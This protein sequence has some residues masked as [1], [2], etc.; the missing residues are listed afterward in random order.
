MKKTIFMLI[1]MATTLLACHKHAAET[2]AY[3]VAIAIKKPTADGVAVLNQIMPVEVTF[4]RNNGGTIHNVLIQILD[5]K[6]VV[7]KTVADNHA[8]TASPYTYSE[9][10]AYKLTAV[11]DY[12]L[13]VT[14]TD[15]AKL[16]P[17]VKEQKFSVK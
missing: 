7:V 12:V 1:L 16:Q 15:D 4:T 8:H 10:S 11:G 17:N 2:D 6:G 3:E 9:A 14:S 5:N 13:K